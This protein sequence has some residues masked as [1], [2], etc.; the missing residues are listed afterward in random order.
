M[1]I[2]LKELSANDVAA[3]GLCLRNSTTAFYQ[4]ESGV[5]HATTAVSTLQSLASRHGAILRDGCEVTQV[6]DGLDESKLRVV[7]V[8]ARDGKGVSGCRF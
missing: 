2:P 7:H 1:Q 4:A 5:L 3:Y 6:I 8:T